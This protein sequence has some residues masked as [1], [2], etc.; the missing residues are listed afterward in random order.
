MEYEF[1]LLA[2]TNS[3]LSSEMIKMKI[4]KLFST[5]CFL[6]SQMTIDF[7]AV[8]FP[9]MFIGSNNFIED[10][11]SAVRKPMYRVFY[12]RAVDLH[13]E[14]ILSCSSEITHLAVVRTEQ[15]L[16]VGLANNQCLLFDVKLGRIVRRFQSPG[17]LSSVSIPLNSSLIYLAFNM[18]VRSIDSSQAQIKMTSV[19]SC[20]ENIVRIAFI[21]EENPDELLI[22]TQSGVLLVWTLN[23]WRSSEFASKGLSLFT[24]FRLLKASKRIMFRFPDGKLGLWDLLTRSP[25]PLPC[26]LAD[27]VIT[28]S[29]WDVQEG[30]SMI[31]Y[32]K[33]YELFMRNFYADKPSGSATINEH[34]PCFVLSPQNNYLFSNSTESSVTYSLE[35]QLQIPFNAPFERSCVAFNE[36]GTKIYLQR[37]YE[38]QCWDLINRSLVC[39][40]PITE[41]DGKVLAMDSYHYQGIIVAVTILG[42]LLVLNMD[43]L[44]LQNCITIGNIDYDH[45]AFLKIFNGRGEMVI[46]NMET[47][48]FF[49]LKNFDMMDR[50]TFEG[51]PI[52]AIAIRDYS[53]ECYCGLRDGSLAKITMG[54]PNSCTTI[55]GNNTPEIKCIAISEESKLLVTASLKKITLWNIDSLSKRNEVEIKRSILSL[56]FLND[57]LLLVGHQSH[58]MNLWDVNELTEIYSDQNLSAKE[59]TEVIANRNSQML[60]YFGK[61]GLVEIKYL[62]KSLL[63]QRKTSATSQITEIRRCDNGR[64]LSLTGFKEKFVRIDPLT[65]APL[66]ESSPH[67]EPSLEF[68]IYS[69]RRIYEINTLRGSM[70][71]S[72]FDSTTKPISLL[73]VNF[74]NPDKYYINKYLKLLIVTGAKGHVMIFSLNDPKIPIAVQKSRIMSTSMVSVD[75]YC[76]NGV[77]RLRK[78]DHR[79]SPFRLI[80]DIL[81]M[82]VFEAHRQRISDLKVVQSRNILLTLSE[83]QRIRAWSLQ[84]NSFIKEIFLWSMASFITVVESQNIIVAATTDAKLSVYSLANYEEEL[85]HISDLSPGEIVGMN[86][87]LVSTNVDLFYSN[88]NIVRL[89]TQSFGRPTILEQFY[90]NAF[91][92]DNVNEETFMVNLKSFKP[93]YQSSNFL[94][95]YFNIYL[96]A[97]RSGLDSLLPQLYE[98]SEIPYPAHTNQISPINLLSAMDSLHLK[99]WIEYVQKHEIPLLMDQGTIKNLMSLVPSFSFSLMLQSIKIMNNFD[100][101]GN[102]I[103]KVGNFQKE[104]FIIQKQSSVFDLESYESIPQDRATTPRYMEFYDMGLQWD[105]TDVTESSQ[106]FLYLYS[107]CNSDDFVLSPY[108]HIIESKWNRYFPLILV[109]AVFQW[110]HVLFYSLSMTNPTI[111]AFFITEFILI[112]IIVL[113]EVI[114][115]LANPRYYFKSAWNYLDWFNIAICITFLI[116]AQNEADYVDNDGYRIMQVIS[117][118]SVAGRGFTFAKVFTQFSVITRM[119]LAMMTNTYSIFCMLVYF[120]VCLSVP[121]SKSKSGNSFVDSILVNY[122]LIFGNI[123]EFNERQY[124]ETILIVFGSIFLP[125]F[126]IN[127]LIAKLS[128]TY[129]ELEVRQKVL[130]LKEMASSLAELEYLEALIRNSFGHKLYVKSGHVYIAADQKLMIKQQDTEKM[131]R[132]VEQVLKMLPQMSKELT[133]IKNQQEQQFAALDKVVRRLE[134]IAPS[135]EHE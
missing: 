134:A 1:H 88:G 54:S 62:K 86:S 37:N 130:I 51:T 100:I 60:V 45:E 94:K 90:I 120:S 71:I 119:T 80:S 55:P 127:F 17:P 132:D 75:V 29:N 43:D 105:F 16:F 28:D 76:S 20:G 70:V 85:V 48:R 115:I 39:S 50:F 5:H 116:V 107:N 30:L 52:T 57:N 44:R 27:M 78:M 124:L 79:S 11:A 18:E 65:L 61:E 74:I 121:L 113:Y 66:S 128:S 125:I 7:L 83:D 131:A 109:N 23:S 103:N 56:T 82:H 135:I 99:P 114:S 64:N 34:Y 92:K 89:D 32:K 19:A 108:R 59:I 129:S 21:D 122:N 102:K 24:E 38:I 13:Y 126:L 12:M 133:T 14:Q 69:G 42:K 97:A 46:A 95:N 35:R 68:S 118:L 31:F 10:W 111:T 25:L 58:C 26:G 36:F 81:S 84:T 91:F 112:G 123:P 15:L 117:L 9:H 93:T 101:T 4:D 87:S 67:P 2:K 47:V 110:M 77:A 22:Q 6:G 49:N 98:V 8:D 3:L 106:M 63:L 72:A 41:T 73:N 104:I 33:G 53:A 96:A 40:Y